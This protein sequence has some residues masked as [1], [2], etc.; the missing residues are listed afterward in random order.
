L[1][2][3]SFTMSNSFNN[4]GMNVNPILGTFPPDEINIQPYWLVV[5]QLLVAQFGQR[6]W[7]YIRYKTVFTTLEIVGLIR[8]YRN[9]LAKNTTDRSVPVAFVSNKNVMTDEERLTQLRSM[10]AI[11]FFNALSCLSTLGHTI[12][13][14]IIQSTCLQSHSSIA[15]HWNCYNALG[16]RLFNYIFVSY[17]TTTLDCVYKAYT[18]GYKEVMYVDAKRGSCRWVGHYATLAIIALSLLFTGCILLPFVLTNVIPMFVIYLWM[19]IIYIGLCVYLVFTSM[20]IRNKKKKPL[21]LPHKTQDKENTNEEKVNQHGYC[22]SM[23]TTNEMPQVAASMLF[24][25]VISTFPILLSIYYNYTQFFYFGESYLKS[26]ENDYLT[27]DT[28]NYFNVLANS[29]QQSLHLVLNLI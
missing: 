1:C 12:W 29:A 11:D 5:L 17:F 10:L 19:S 23:F 16:Y 8:I 24:A 25:M 21:P 9:R 13:Y 28:M 2:F 6:I 15:T 22:S 4:T 3:R 26:I 7:N 27:R 20:T 18:L 14:C